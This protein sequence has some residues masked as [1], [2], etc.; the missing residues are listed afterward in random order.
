MLLF[1]NE[2]AAFSRGWGKRLVI[3]VSA[4]QVMQRLVEGRQ[5]VPWAEKAPRKLVKAR[6]C[7]ALHRFAKGAT[8]LTDQLIPGKP[9]ARKFA[10]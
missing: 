6:L 3:A 8:V 1:I 4:P 2:L 9:L 5:F 7:Q 10:A